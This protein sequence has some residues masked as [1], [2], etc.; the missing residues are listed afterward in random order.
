[1]ATRI[2]NRINVA[3]C[4]E[5]DELK[6]PPRRWANSNQIVVAKNHLP[7]RRVFGGPCD[8]AGA[9]FS[10]FRTLPRTLN[11]HSAFAMHEM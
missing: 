3:R 7:S 1:M 9:K 6:Y 4:D 10:M 2:A 5:P 11:S 8:F